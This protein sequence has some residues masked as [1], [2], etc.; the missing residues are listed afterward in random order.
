MKL[1][2]TFLILFGLS[3][4]FSESGISQQRWTMTTVMSFPR[5]RLAVITLN[6][7]LYAIGGRD[8]TSDSLKYIE[9]FDGSAWTD[10]TATYPMPQGISGMAA[11][12]LNDTIYII[13]GK[14]GGGDTSPNV[15]AFS[16]DSWESRRSCGRRF[17]TC[18]K[19]A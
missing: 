11:V 1:L 10:L 9:E 8:N 13:G 12:V 19:G 4:A 2:K 16:G 7:K 6:D 15:W 14:I 5:D 3:L 18:P 17:L